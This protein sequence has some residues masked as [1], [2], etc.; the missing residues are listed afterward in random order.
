MESKEKVQKDREFYRKKF[1]ELLNK[2]NYIPQIDEDGRIE[3]IIQCK[4]KYR[5]YYFLSNMGYLMSLH[6]EKDPWH[7]RIP[8]VTWCGSNRTRPQ[9]RYTLM[10]S[11]G[12]SIRISMPELIIEHFDP[13]AW[14]I[15]NAHRNDEEPYIIHHKTSVHAYD[16]EN[17]PQKINRLSNLQ[18]VKDERHKDSYKYTSGQKHLA[19]K[20]KKIETGEINVS[21]I[22]VPDLTGFIESWIKSLTTPQDIIT[23]IPDS[24][25]P[26]GYNKV[27]FGTTDDIEFLEEKKVG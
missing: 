9:F 5:P 23:V 27:I 14:E 12:G 20:F 2:N 16:A 8:D 3:Q 24:K 7:I 4:D 22:V 10:G 6:K 17:N 21:Q 26:E 11:E 18:V 15:Y 13:E 1:D 25:N 19:D